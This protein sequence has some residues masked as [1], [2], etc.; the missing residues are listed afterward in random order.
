[1]G[2][3][4]DTFEYVRHRHACNYHTEMP[5]PA[6]KA[7]HRHRLPIHAT[8]KWACWDTTSSPP[9]PPS[10]NNR[11]FIIISPSRYSRKPLH[12]IAIIGAPPRH[13][14]IGVIAIS[15]DILA[16][17]SRA[18]PAAFYWYRI[19]ASKESRVH[20]L[21]RLRDGAL[22]TYQNIYIIYIVARVY[23]NA[24]TIFT[25]EKEMSDRV[26]IFSA[27]ELLYQAR[28]WCEMGEGHTCHWYLR[29][30]AAAA[31]SAAIRHARLTYRY[32]T[33]ISAR[34]SRQCRFVGIFHYA[35]PVRIFI[36]DMRLYLLHG[37]ARITMPVMPAPPPIVLGSTHQ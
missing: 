11:R 18:G 29:A 12:D 2:L 10:E 34:A 25:Y 9:P 21:Y 20:W 28:C 1:M 8:E 14:T 22:T 3:P 5:A 27:R 16:T 24:A 6:P 17:G 23:E 13:A 32:A 37:I 26:M 35:M 30:F 15:R 4:S 19:V 36:D 33:L 7:G 31:S